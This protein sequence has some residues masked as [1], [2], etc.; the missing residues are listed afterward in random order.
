M[1]KLS[2]EFISALPS[3]AEILSTSLVGSV[4]SYYKEDQKV[5]TSGDTIHSL[6]CLVDNSKQVRIPTGSFNNLFFAS[7]D[8]VQESI[9]DEEIESIDKTYKSVLAVIASQPKWAGALKGQ[10]GLLNAKQELEFGSYTIVGYRIKTF[11]GTP[12]LRSTAYV[13]YDS[14]KVLADAE[15]AS[16]DM[17]ALRLTGIKP[18]ISTGYIDHVSYEYLLVPTK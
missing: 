13:G 6:I 5:L 8:T 1:A 7:K 18:S 14:A 9:T 3:S 2:T 12:S 15:N 10:S 17:R 4:I 16:I 11:N